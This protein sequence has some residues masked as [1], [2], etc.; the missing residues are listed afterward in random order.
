MRATLLCRL[1]SPAARGPG[2]LGFPGCGAGPFP[3]ALA[4]E[5]GFYLKQAH[6]C[7]CVGQQLGDGADLS[8]QGAW[9]GVL[10][11]FGVFFA[12]FY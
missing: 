9:V 12:G 3:R 7:G 1:R 8:G 4:F 5:A 2:L 6:G 11:S 10:G